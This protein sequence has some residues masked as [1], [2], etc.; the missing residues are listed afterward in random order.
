MSDTK[1]TQM[2]VIFIN[3]TKQCNIDCHRCYLTPENR[4]NPAKMSLKVLQSIL[5]SNYCQKAD[6]ILLIW[7]GGEASLLGEEYIRE[8]IFTAKSLLPKAR[9]TMVTNLFNLPDWL[10]RIAKEHF[11]SRIE[12]TFAAGAKSMLNGDE[13][14]YQ[15][16][17][18]K[19][20]KKGIKA[21]LTIPVNLETNIETLKAGADL[22]LQIA[23]E[24]GANQWEF[25]ISIDFE[26]FLSDPKFSRLG[27]PQLPPTAT[28]KELED[29]ALSIVTDYE[30]LVHV[31]DFKN[32]LLDH[33]RS[34]SKSLA[35]N[36]CQE[37]NFVTVNP[38]GD[39]TTNPLFSDIE[40]TFLGNVSRLPLDMILDSPKRHRR[41][42]EERIRISDCLKCRHF[43]VCGGG[44]SHVPVRDGSGTC[45]GLYALW[46]YFFPEY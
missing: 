14:A 22:V 11:G 32:S 2:Q 44:P 12:T 17:F 7:Q 20:L 40:G 19:N 46:A 8:M 4:S 31:T 38:N 35:F 27:Y 13:Q 3:L 21:G 15:S 42:L 26:S 5:R 45:S 30:D 29:Y 25:D 1:S 24:T 41:S 10:I 33:A 43:D 36:V 28:Y 23:A 39:V 16:R 37:L 9:Q 6:E 18:T 34:R